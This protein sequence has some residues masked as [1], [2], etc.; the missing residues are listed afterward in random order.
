MKAMKWQRVGRCEK[1]ASTT[2]SSPIWPDELAHLLMRPFQELFEQTKLVHDLERRGMD[3]VAAKV[4]Q[5]VRVLFQHHHL[6]AGACQQIAEHHAGGSASGD[7][8]A[9]GDD[10]VH[11]V[12]PSCHSREV[13][14]RARRTL[15]TGSRS[16]RDDAG[17]YPLASAMA[18]R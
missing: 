3:G 13:G 1:S 10:F 17:F 8:A 18:S 15:G 6:D 12:A 16:S 9:S 2:R 5:E 14:S 7:A 11:V 4:A